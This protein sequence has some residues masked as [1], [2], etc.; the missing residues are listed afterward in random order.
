M[1]EKLLGCALYDKIKG[2][3]VCFSFCNSK[4]EYI[5]SNVENAIF[6]YKNLNDLQPKIVCEYDLDT[7]EV[8]PH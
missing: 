8:T 3:H 5:R 6:A 2:K 1:A 4:A 7:G